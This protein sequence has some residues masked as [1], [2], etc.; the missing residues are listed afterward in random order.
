MNN[1]NDSIYEFSQNHN[2]NVFFGGIELIIVIVLLC[3]NSNI[4]NLHRQ[5]GIKIPNY[6]VNLMNNINILI[7]IIIL[8]SYRQM[9]FV[10][11]V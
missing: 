7:N 6:R 2:G 9:K 5:L 4:K 11:G 8:I 10:G 1:I 3:I